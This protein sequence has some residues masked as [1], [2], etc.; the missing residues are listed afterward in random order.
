VSE[1]ELAGSGALHEVSRSGVQPEESDVL[2]IG[3]DEEVQ[4]TAHERAEPSGG[5]VFSED[6]P[7]MQALF[8]QASAMQQRMADAQAE[9]AEAR[10]T[11]HAGGGLVTATVNG[12]GELLSLDIAPEACDP[13]DT[14]TLADLVVAAV[15]NASAKANAQA[16]EQLED[17]SGGLGLGG[18]GVLGR[19]GLPGGSARAEQDSSDRD[20]DRQTPWTFG[21]PPD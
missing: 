19:G 7:D 14:E 21:H 4:R 20:T 5:I 8:E 3:H 1:N 9:L 11:G 13:S 16:A 18:L 17:L 12:T 6:M 15:R 2:L 10:I